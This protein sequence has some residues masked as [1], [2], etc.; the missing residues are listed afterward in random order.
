MGRGEAESAPKA[1]GSFL[2]LLERVVDAAGAVRV[3]EG[4]S[5]CVPA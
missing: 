4:E 2:I 5:R 1:K 3:G